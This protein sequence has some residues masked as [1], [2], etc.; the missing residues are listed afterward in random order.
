[1]RQARRKVLRSALAATSF[2]LAVATVEGVAAK[3]ARVGYLGQAP[4]ASLAPRLPVRPAGER[5]R[6]KQADMATATVE[7]AKGTAAGVK[8]V[9]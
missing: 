1:M 4:A 8:R 6:G 5:R 3:I 2:M 7:T 9:C